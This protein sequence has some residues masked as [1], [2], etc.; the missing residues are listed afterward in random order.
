[1]REPN[2][3]T[4]D[5]SG[6]G[7]VQPSHVDALTLVQLRLSQHSRSR[8]SQMKLTSGIAAAQSAV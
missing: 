1:M 5:H 4:L 8:A 2:V 7:A 6:F 3:A